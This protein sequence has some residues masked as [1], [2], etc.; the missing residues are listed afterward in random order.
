MT[1][2]SVFLGFLIALIP[3]FLWH[4]LSGGEL[5]KL[6]SLILFS[7]VGFWLGHLLALWRHWNFLKLG[8]IYLGTAIIFSVIF[9]IAGSW[10][11]TYTNDLI[12]RK[13]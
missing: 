13:R 2:A 11:S 9:V 3:A 5:R 6:V 10:L 8:P 7:C 4:F 12:P 1:I